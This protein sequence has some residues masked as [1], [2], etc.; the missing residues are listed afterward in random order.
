MKKTRLFLSLA[1]LPSLFS[2]A[3]TDVCQKKIDSLSNRIN[4]LE[5]NANNSFNEKLVQA[6]L[7]TNLG[8]NF[9]VPGQTKLIDK[10]GIGSCFSIGLSLNKTFKNSPTI[11]IAT[12][13]EFD[14][15]TNRYKTVDSVYYDYVGSKITSK[16]NE[17]D[18]K[19]TFSLQERNQKS[20]YVSIPLMMLFRTS[21]I[22]DFRYF[23]K[24][25]IR[26]SFLIK[27]TVN[28]YGIDVTNPAQQIANVENNSFTT[29]G[30]MFFY[31]GSIGLSAG[32]EWKFISTTSLVAE[33]GYF[34]GITPLHLERKEA[35]QT[36]YTVDAGTRTYFSNKANQ[37]Q[38]LF[39][40][41]I[42]F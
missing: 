8:M 20:I 11:G 2:F 30:D 16:A 10:N 37:N 12:G 26:N 40:I 27:N 32:A 5:S 29:P 17:P 42:L 24:F 33:V 3:Q 39:K 25:G 34:Y 18:S 7:T 6:G 22:G 15:E 9:I 23:G 14:F 19:G 13:I 35:N 36:L 38:L 41:S 31:K 1:I 21:M 28:D 4:Y